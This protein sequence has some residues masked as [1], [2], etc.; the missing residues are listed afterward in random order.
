MDI[1]NPGAKTHWPKKAEGIFRKIFLISSSVFA[2]L[3]GSSFMFNAKFLT[4]Y[5]SFLVK[6]IV[7]TWLASFVLW[8][9]FLIV[10]SKFGNAI[11]SMPSSKPRSK[12]LG[13]IF[14]FGWLISLIFFFLFIKTNPPQ[15]PVTNIIG[16]IT[17]GGSILFLPI[18]G[19][20]LGNK[21]VRILTVIPGIFILSFLIIYLFILRPHKLTGRSMEP[22]FFNG[23]FALSE[24]ITYYFNS[25]KRGDVV[26]FNSPVM[27]GEVFARIIGLPGEYISIADGHV[28]INNEILD[29]PYVNGETS[30]KLIRRFISDT[31]TPIPQNS[32]AI[33]GDNRKHSS[34]SRDYGFISSKDIKSRIFYIYWP[35]NKRGV[36]KNPL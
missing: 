9:I 25:P 13:L 22:N 28:Y 20:L 21:L 2:L 16:F 26:I 34:D 7:Y 30:F 4:K 1:Y 36:V 8:T 31:N 5:V 35:Q 24:K 3:A 27:Q 29:E 33:L 6:P 15:G 14:L 23:E 18:W 32:F 10:N 19:F 12:S 11:K 17:F